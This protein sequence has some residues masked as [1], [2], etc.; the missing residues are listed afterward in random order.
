M[1]DFGIWLFGAVCGGCVG[2][3]LGVLIRVPGKDK[4]NKDYG[5]PDL[6]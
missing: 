1:H 4:D 6:N 5:N 3:L 2:F